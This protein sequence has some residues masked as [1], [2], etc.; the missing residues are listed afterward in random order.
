MKTQHHGH[1]KKICIWTTR[2]DRTMWMEKTSKGPTPRQT[3]SYSQLIA[4]ERGKSVFIVDYTL[5]CYP[6][7][8]QQP[9]THVHMNGL[10]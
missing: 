10:I 4:V 1:L 2:I 8:S 3:N 9:E 7:S 6:F 5:I